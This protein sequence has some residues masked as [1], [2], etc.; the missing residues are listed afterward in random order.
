MDGFRT[1][2]SF[3]LSILCL[4]FHFKWYRHADTSDERELSLHKTENFLS[5]KNWCSSWSTIDRH[6]PNRRKLFAKS[7]G[8]DNNNSVVVRI[9]STALS[10]I[11]HNNGLRHFIYKMLLWFSLTSFNSNIEFTF[12]R[13]SNTVHWRG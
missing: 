12:A 3:K 9:M 10:V 2:C 4:T 11:C 7:V 13:T 8:N 1:I 6:T 5:A